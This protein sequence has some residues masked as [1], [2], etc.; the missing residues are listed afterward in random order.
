M[1]KVAVYADISV[2]VMC[3]VAV[4]IRSIVSCNVAK[5]SVLYAVLILSVAWVDTILSEGKE[6]KRRRCSLGDSLRVYAA[7]VF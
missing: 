4:G 3:E 2:R 1:S 5:V 7:R 6:C